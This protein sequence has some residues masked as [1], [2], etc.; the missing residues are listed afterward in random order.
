MVE[1][2]VMRE[3]RVWR[4]LSCISAPC[5]CDIQSFIEGGDRREGDGGQDDEG[6]EGTVTNLVFF[7]EH[8]Q[9]TKEGAKVLCL[10]VIVRPGRHIC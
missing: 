10:S 2:S 3:R 7:V 9:P 4:I 1:K 8:W 5:D 6:L